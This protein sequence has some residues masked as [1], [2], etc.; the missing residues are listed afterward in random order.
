[1]TDA[2]DWSMKLSDWTL[3]D[4]IL[5]QL[6]SSHASG[7]L[8]DYGKPLD[9]GREDLF[10][11]RLS[12]LVWKYAELKRFDAGF[13]VIE[14]AKAAFPRLLAGGDQRRA[15]SSIRARSRKASTR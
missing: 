9:K 1:M 15:S 11:F 8:L 13:S 12:S 4:G 2:F 7:R 10:Q 14:A 3:A 5:R 6:F